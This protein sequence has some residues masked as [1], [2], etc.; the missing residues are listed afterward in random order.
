MTSVLRMYTE[1]IHND[2]IGEITPYIIQVKTSVC[3]D[4][5]Q[6]LYITIP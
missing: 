3:R 6:K 1:S 4:T 2:Y 5:T